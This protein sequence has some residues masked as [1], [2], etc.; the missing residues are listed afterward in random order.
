MHVVAVSIKTYSFPLLSLRCVIIII[1]YSPTICVNAHTRFHSRAHNQHHWKLQP[2]RSLEQNMWLKLET[3]F[4]GCEHRGH[5]RD[6]ICDWWDLSKLVFLLCVNCDS[7]R[8]GATNGSVCRQ[9]PILIISCIPVAFVDRELNRVSCV[10][11]SWSDYDIKTC[12]NIP[13]IID[14]HTTGILCDFVGCCWHD[15]W[16]ACASLH[17]KLHMRQ[18]LLAHALHLA[19][20]LF[21]T[22]TTE[23]AL[24]SVNG[25]LQLITVISLMVFI[26]SARLILLYSACRI[27]VSKSGVSNTTLQ[28]CA[29][30]IR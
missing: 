15:N 5:L 22:A 3:R 27:N 19:Q 11:V 1:L 12:L 2:P 17:A 26:L 16:H 21:S 10:L 6:G 18:N 30:C 13:C 28:F 24:Q 29:D 14:G 20:A 4:A 25:Q 23:D 9:Q 8:L 7:N